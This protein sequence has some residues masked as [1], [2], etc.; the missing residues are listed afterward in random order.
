MTE[1][2]VTPNVKQKKYFPC[3]VTYLDFSLLVSI[4]QQ[5]REEY[6]G[7]SLK[8]LYFIFF[9]PHNG[10]PWDKRLAQALPY[11]EFNLKDFIG[12]Y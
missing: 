3:I 6:T 9:P 10:K 1:Q 4:T 7:C 12:Q 8:A 2:M 5:E 11:Y